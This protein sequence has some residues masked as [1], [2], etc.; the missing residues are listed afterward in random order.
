MKRACLIVL[1]FFLLAA[2]LYPQFKTRNPEL[3]SNP[4]F[5]VFFINEN[6]GWVVGS[7]GTILS[8]TDGGKNWEGQS[9][10]YSAIR[11][12]FFI[13][14]NTG[15]IVTGGDIFD[16]ADGAIHK[17]IDGGKTWETQILFHWDYAGVNYPHVRFKSITFIDYNTGWA[18]GD[19]WVNDTLN[20]ATIYRT[21]D[22]GNNW[23]EIFN[24]NKRYSS[25]NKIEFENNN[26][27][28]INYT[29]NSFPE[30]DKTTDGGF[31]WEKIDLGFDNGTI[32]CFEKYQDKI[33]I[34]QN[35][36]GIWKVNTDGSEPV[37]LWNSKN[38]LDKFNGFQP[39]VTQIEMN[40][41]ICVAAGYF[42]DDFID[43]KIPFTITTNNYWADTE[44]NIYPDLKMQQDGLASPPDPFNSIYSYDGLK[45]YITCNIYRGNSK[46]L[47]SFGNNLLCSSDQCK[48]LTYASKSNFEKNIYGIDFNNTTGI[49]CGENGTIL[50][51]ADGGNNWIEE[52]PITEK[53]L[54][55]LDLSSN[56]NY[57]I[58]GEKGVLLNSADDGRTWSENNINNS[59]YIYSIFFTD[60][61]TGWLCGGYK[62]DYG[63]PTQHA[64]IYRTTDGGKNWIEK[65]RETGKTFY[66]IYFKD[67]K[68]G[69][70]VGSKRYVYTTNDGGETWNF[71]QQFGGA[72]WQD[73]RNFIKVKF[74][75]ENIGFIFFND[76]DYKYIYKTTNGGSDWI[77]LYDNY[78]KYSAAW[79]KNIDKLKD[80]VVIDENTMYAFADGKY[81]APEHGVILKTTDGALTWEVIHRELRFYNCATYYNNHVWACGEKG[82]IIND[83]GNSFLLTNINEEK[84]NVPSDFSLEQN[85]PNPF[86]PVTTIQYKIISTTKVVL[87]IYDVLGREVTTLMNEEKMPGNY[88][89]KF[90]GSNLSSGVYFYRMQTNEFIETKKL[91]LLK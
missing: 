28:Y 66:S 49:I 52:K 61:N 13:D 42:W 25:I 38:Q 88:E 54:I 70:A 22:G 32:M 51:S 14:D 5:K 55:A 17:T 84:Q 10:G 31:T 11:D 68:N 27:G 23:Q 39:I 40:E 57:W 15:W 58:G 7:L 45:W 16:S 87:K 77:E 43:A 80:V 85:Y 46:G 21:T 81:I 24:N 89:I 63:D 79:N 72:S 12:L 19:K 47:I 73:N 59:D 74:I 36:T 20:V 44:I 76:N 62:G 37:L 91:V 4:L 53:N 18:S 3:Q 9:I 65:F 41:N 60:D 71:Q 8:T 75:N 35:N 90:N 29:N 50:R 48:T 56:N 26:V 1:A 64:V 67:D 86:N 82:F 34:S 78:E 2:N 33:F 6:V 69:W 30:V 83:T